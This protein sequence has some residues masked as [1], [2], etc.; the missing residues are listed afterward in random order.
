MINKNE[1]AYEKIKE[2]ILN[3]IYPAST[4]SETMLVDKLGISRTPIRSAL[5]RLHW[6]AL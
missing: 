1:M 4:L 5:Q 3:G 2:G 6:K